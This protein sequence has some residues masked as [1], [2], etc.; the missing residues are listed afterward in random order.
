MHLY[1]FMYI[2][3]QN[4][5]LARV[6]LWFQLPLSNRSSIL[7]KFTK[8]QT[9]VIYKINHEMVYFT[10]YIYIWINKKLLVIHSKINYSIL[11]VQLL[12]KMCFGKFA[13]HI[14]KKVKE[15]K[16]KGNRYWDKETI[17]DEHGFIGFKFLHQYFS[18]FSFL[19]SRFSFQSS[20]I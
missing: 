17:K 11:V 1:P 9:V 20:C 15:K 5:R 13:H 2:H 6:L 3:V 4:I 7:L 12:Q 14:P 18:L 10:R 16:Y 19:T 8:S